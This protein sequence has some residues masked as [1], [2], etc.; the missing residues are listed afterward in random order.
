M[1]VMLQVMP[2]TCQELM[3][4]VDEQTSFHQVANRILDC[5]PI[6]VSAYIMKRWSF[7][8]SI[9]LPLEQLRKLDY[10]VNPE[11]RKHCLA[12]HNAHRIIEKQGTAFDWDFFP[13][14]P[15]VYS[16]TSSKDFTFV[17]EASSDVIL[18][19]NMPI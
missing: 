3:E 2:T 11:S 12:L 8:A 4:Q 1:L 10:S 19:C 5:S 16:W 15:E 9:Y 17:E 7:G 18:C 6:D 13:E 14:L